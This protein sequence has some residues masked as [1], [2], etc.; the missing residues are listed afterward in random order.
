MKINKKIQR[1]NKR[2]FKRQCRQAIKDM[3]KLITKEIDNEILESLKL[4]SFQ[5]EFING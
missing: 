4:Y 5:K 2:R 3:G 1:I